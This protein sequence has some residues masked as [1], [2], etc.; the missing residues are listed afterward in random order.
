MLTARHW[1]R[2]TGRVGVKLSDGSIAYSAEEVSAG[3]TLPKV[4]PV[5]AL[6]SSANQ[7]VLQQLKQTDFVMNSQASQ[8]PFSPLAAQSQTAAGL[9]PRLADSVSTKQLP[10]HN[11]SLACTASTAQLN[12]SKPLQLTE[13]VSKLRSNLLPYQS[14]VPYVD[15]EDQDEDDALGALQELDALLAPPA[16]TR[17]QVPDTGLRS[18]AYSNTMQGQRS[19]SVRSSA[20]CAHTSTAEQITSRNRPTPLQNPASSG[21]TAP[22]GSALQHSLTS[23]R[24]SRSRAFSTVRSC[25]TEG[26]HQQQR[27]A[28]V[29]TAR[30]LWTADQDQQAQTR[31]SSPVLVR[32]LKR[33]SIATDQSSPEAASPPLATHADCCQTN[34]ASISEQPVLTAAELQSVHSASHLHNMSQAAVSTPAAGATASSMAVVS[35]VSPAQLSSTSLS[36]ERLNSRS[37]LQF[38]QRQQQP[39]SS[40]SS[41]SSQGCKSEAPVVLHGQTKNPIV[42]PA[43]AV[44]T[45]QHIGAQPGAGHSVSG[46]SSLSDVPVHV[47]PHDALPRSSSPVD[48]LV[49]EL[50]LQHLMD[51]VPGLAPAMADFAIRVCRAHLHGQFGFSLYSCPACKGALAPAAMLRLLHL[52]TLWAFCLLCYPHLHSQM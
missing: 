47:A 23:D 26:N 11:G 37:V 16:L 7:R 33:P 42:S 43:T 46:A 51:K 24:D 48:E 50:Q 32:I 18:S 25:W 13:H 39:H 3:L 45:Q 1:C 36:N 28:G 15:Y 10:R 2:L 20:A 35:S 27:A 52:S 22:N 41:V 17:N 40:V 8:A 14:P 34:T 21:L 38:L 19:P 31:V 5:S 29:S 9:L 30:S 4:P 6:G 12:G 49:L 44:T